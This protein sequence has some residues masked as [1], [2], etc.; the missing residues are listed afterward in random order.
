MRLGGRSTNVLLSWRRLKLFSNKVAIICLLHRFRPF[1]L[2]PIFNV[3][4]IVLVT[5][6]VFAVTTA[7]L[8]F[9]FPL[10]FF[11]LFS[12]RA[13]LRVIALFF[14]LLAVLD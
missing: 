2:S 8:G 3:L 6:H 11:S 9:V 10:S 14:N 4:N 7:S 12:N 1:R 13:L 5:I